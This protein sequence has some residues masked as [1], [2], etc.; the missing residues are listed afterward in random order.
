MKT[1]G[2]MGWVTK[3]Q[4][5]LIETIGVVCMAADKGSKEVTANEVKHFECECP[6]CEALVRVADDN[7]IS[8]ASFN[9]SVRNAAKN[10]LLVAHNWKSGF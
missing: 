6:Y 5:E 10:S 3:A 2:S 4:F 9:K 8:G 7:V 1:D